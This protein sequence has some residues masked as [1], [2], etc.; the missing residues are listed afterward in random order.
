MY[1]CAWVRVRMCV[2]LCTSVKTESHAGHRRTGTEGA[3][4]NQDPEDRGD[5]E[6][7]TA[8]FPTRFINWKSGK[9]SRLPRDMKLH[10]RIHLTLISRE[11]G[12][13]WVRGG[14]L[15]W[16][17]S[18]LAAPSGVLTPRPL[19][20]PA[21]SAFTVCLAMLLGKKEGVLIKKDWEEINGTI[22]DWIS[23]LG[24]AVGFSRWKYNLNLHKPK[25]G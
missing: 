5:L 8:P 20:L 17:D 21:D 11:R 9:G 24:R 7:V 22:Y 16:S 19:P 10:A 2:W 25:E 15:D 12:C 4:E 14:C 23:I 13:V 18:P 1:L 6:T 3:W